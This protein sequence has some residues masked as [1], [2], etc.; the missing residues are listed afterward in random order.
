MDASSAIP[1]LVSVTRE[2]CSDSRR[3]LQYYRAHVQDAAHQVA[4]S[5]I[6]I[7]DA[8][9]AL[10]RLKSVPR[11]AITTPPPLPEVLPDS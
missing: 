5:K 4:Q 9:R 11:V 10:A 1:I 6:L 3:E 8:R 7:A 2:R